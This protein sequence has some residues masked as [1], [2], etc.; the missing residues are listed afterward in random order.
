MANWFINQKMTRMGSMGQKGPMM[1]SPLHQAFTDSPTTKD[2]PE[3]DRNTKKPLASNE[4]QYM[5]GLTKD[6]ASGNIL[7]RGASHLRN[8]GSDMV[9]SPGLTSS[10]Q[11]SSSGKITK[12]S[13]R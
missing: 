2:R 11:G 3:L 6:Q 1:Q 4:R 12:K 10:F 13:L 5:G 9:N 8:F 7:Q